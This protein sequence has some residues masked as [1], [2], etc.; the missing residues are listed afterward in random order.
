MIENVHEGPTPRL[1]EID[2]AWLTGAL[3]SSG[4][5]GADVAGFH[6]TPIGAGQSAKT[7]RFELTYSQM[8]SN[9]AGRPAPTSLIGKFP[10]DNLMARSFAVQQSMYQREVDFYRRLYSRVTSRVPMCYLA[11]INTGGAGFVLLLEDIR[12]A[13]AGDQLEGCNVELAR[14]ALAQLSGLHAPTWCD[15]S[16]REAPWLR[17][18]GAVADYQRF[19]K[20]YRKLMPEFLVRFCD[21]LTPIEREL[22]VQLGNCRT[23]PVNQPFLDTFSAVHFDFRLDNL[24]IGT[25]QRADEL[26]VIDWQLVRTADPLTDVSYFLGGSLLPEIRR[27]A[28]RDLVRSYYRAICDAGV[29]GFNWEDCWESYRRAAFHGFCIVVYASVGLEQTERNVAL[30]TTGAKRHACHAL[31]LEAAE[32]LD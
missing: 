1:D 2:A 13:V 23:F 26:T 19:E 9:G 8:G 15:A 5:E 4:F 32:L 11:D 3:R 7:V 17:G 30:L 22:F 18:R 20:L 10:S 29:K 27:T 31:D 16:L 24:L 28:E 6:C 25:G 12:D 21:H 14:T